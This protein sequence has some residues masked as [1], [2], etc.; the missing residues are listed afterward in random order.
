MHPFINKPRLCYN[1]TNHPGVRKLSAILL[2]AI[3]GFSQY[4]RQLS[5][6]ECKLSNAFKSPELK[7]DCEK[8]AGFAKEESG[9]SVPKAHLHLHLD[10]YFSA[11]KQTISIPFPKTNNTV[12]F[13]FYI[14]KECEGS[15]P[16]PWQPPNS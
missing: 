11:P 4:A 10:E 2:I 8:Q 9:P 1:Q 16:A 3:F 15:Y 12:L 13:S 5:Y 14:E 6:L 7:C